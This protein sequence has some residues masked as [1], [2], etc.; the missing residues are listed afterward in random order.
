MKF[1]LT[2]KRPKDE[3]TTVVL[4][5]YVDQR[6]L[7]TG[8]GVT[9]PTKSWDKG[10]QRIRTGTSKNLIA[11]QSE[12]DNAVQAMRLGAYDFIKK[13]FEDNDQIREVI[14][15]ALAQRSMQDEPD[16]AAAEILGNSPAMRSVPS[17]VLKRDFK[18]SSVGGLTSVISAS[19]GQ[20][21]RPLTRMRTPAA[22]GST[23]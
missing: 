22:S 14:S 21:R 6:R 17:R 16:Q 12:L 11:L 15:R 7:K 3:K 2:L 4:I 9:I 10:N 23:P 18:P 13:P 1:N 20:P 5:A 8:L 19:T